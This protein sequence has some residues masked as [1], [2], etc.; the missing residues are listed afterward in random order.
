[1]PDLDVVE[2]LL[3][4]LNYKARWLQLSDE[5]I[6]HF[7]SKGRFAKD[8]WNDIEPHLAQRDRERELDRSRRYFETAVR[9]KLISDF[10]DNHVRTQDKYAK[11]TLGREITLYL[12]QN[13]TE[14]LQRYLYDVLELGLDKAHKK[15]KWDQWRGGY[16]GHVWELAKGSAR[17]AIV[18]AIFGVADSRYERVVFSLLILIFNSLDAGFRAHFFNAWRIAV[19]LDSQFARTRR[20]L[21]E[22]LS[23]SDRQ[24]NFEEEGG[25]EEILRKSNRMTVRLYINGAFVSLTSVIAL[26]ELAESIIW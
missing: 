16:V 13:R 5:E 3:N 2:E 24:A 14:E 10:L 8:W 6:E 7:T 4:S 26:W 19:S 22:E 11:D 17:L 9:D 23:L 25:E 1:M 20:L 21:K 15:R 12:D 18:I